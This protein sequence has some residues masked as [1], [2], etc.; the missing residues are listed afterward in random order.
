MRI[1]AADSD[2]DVRTGVS[3]Y[4]RDCGY[5]VE[6]AEDGERVPELIGQHEAD[7]VLLD[8][9]GSKEGGPRGLE[10]MVASYPEL[11][12]VVIS[13]AGGVG[14]AMDA[15]RRGAWDFVAKPLDDLSL[16]A[17]AI[18]HA[19]ERRD[20]R[21]QARERQLQIERQVQE[22]GIALRWANT[23][24][25]HKT[26]A[27]REVL[28]TIEAEKQECHHQILSQVETAVLPVLEG[29]IRES[30]YSVRMKLEQLRK[31]LQEITSPFTNHLTRRFASLTPTEVRICQMIRRGMSSKDMAQA[32]GTATETIDGHRKSIRRKLKITHSGANLAAFLQSLEEMSP[33]G[34]ESMSEVHHGS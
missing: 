21:R 33:L 31:S 11:P 27:L 26:V 12:I 28:G 1:I 14:E 34:K 22:Q 10:Q 16:L 5:E 4:L 32:E 19:I 18:E 24:L 17:R 29:A 15:I 7:L 23:V 9:R 20:L 6:E 8:P 25:E 3:L 30:S 2:R 13:S